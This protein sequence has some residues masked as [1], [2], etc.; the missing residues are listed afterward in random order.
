MSRR[1]RSITR[2]K[3]C[4]YTVHYATVLVHTA[5]LFVVSEFWHMKVA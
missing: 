5:R 3:V 4:V 2:F 1:Y